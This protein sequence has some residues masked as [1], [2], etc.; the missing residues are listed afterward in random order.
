MKDFAD[1]AYNVLKRR[2]N[3]QDSTLTIE[4]VNKK[5]DTLAQSEATRRGS[6]AADSLQPF[7]VKLSAKEQKWLIR[8]ILKDV[9]LAGLTENTV[10]KAYHPDAKKKLESVGDLRTIVEELFDQSVRAS[11]IEIELFKAISPMLA[12]RV[13]VPKIIAKMQNQPFYVETKLDGE[14]TQ[15]HKEGNKYC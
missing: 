4:D 1:V 13:P 15:I 6:Q 11:N 10:L 12:D 8:I 7:L 3:S 14:R 5:L 9:K 2:T